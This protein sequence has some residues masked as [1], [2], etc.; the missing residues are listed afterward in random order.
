SVI[1]ANPSWS[2]LAPDVTFLVPTAVDSDDHS[3]TE[4]QRI[5]FPVAGGG[6]RHVE[7]RVRTIEPERDYVLAT[8]V[9]VEFIDGA[10]EWERVDRHPVT[11]L[12]GRRLFLELLGQAMTMSD[13][14][15]YHPAALAVG[16]EGM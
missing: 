12:P 11:G 10:P 5:P 16:L 6:H 9:D 1:V 7:I 2:D 14:H 4:R 15:R 3:A 8:C 13:R